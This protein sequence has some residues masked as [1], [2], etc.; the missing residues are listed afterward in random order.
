MTSALR[1]LHSSNMPSRHK[2]QLMS[3]YEDLKGKTEG[4]LPGTKHLRAGAE[5]VRSGGESLVIGGALAAAHVKL[6][7]GL[8]VKVGKANIPLDGVVAAIGIAGGIAMA[9]E[10]VGTDLANAGNAALSVLAFRKGFA[11]LA[12]REKRTGGTV[13]GS[14]NGESSGGDMGEDAIEAAARA[15]G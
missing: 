3:W 6:K 11:F 12:E 10:D 4:Y 9:H 2:S 13:G 7:T 5:A 8:D 14:F 1:A 15:L